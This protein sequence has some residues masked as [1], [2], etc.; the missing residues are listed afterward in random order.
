MLSVFK[1]DAITV[2]ATRKVDCKSAMSQRCYFCWGFSKGL[3]EDR[4]QAGDC[5]ARQ[6]A[7]G[8]LKHKSWKY[9]DQRSAVITDTKPNGG[10]LFSAKEDRHYAEEREP[11]WA[12]GKTQGFLFHCL[13]RWDTG[14]VANWKPKRHWKENGSRDSGGQMWSEMRTVDVEAKNER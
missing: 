4:W 6:T 10:F 13:G 11:I 14:E 8:W 3:W 2:R 7:Q 5:W 9:R 1:K 12:N